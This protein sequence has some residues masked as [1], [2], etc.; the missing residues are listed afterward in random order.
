MSKPELGPQGSPRATQH[1]P[2]SVAD[3]AGHALLGVVLGTAVLVGCASTDSESHLT[4]PDSRPGATGPSVVVYRT[5]TCG[6]CK[7]YEDYL[8][9]HGYAIR[10]EVLDDLEPIRM[11]LD[12]PAAAASCH[13]VLI[14]GYAVEG[15][16]PV[17]AI[18]KMLDDRSSIDGISIPGMPSNAPGMGD[19]D[20]NPIEV[21]SFRD[22]SVEPFMTL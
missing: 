7:K 6:C 20:G 8:R 12:I 17:E 10:S 4:A 18:D 14:D 1:N 11:E 13:T 3:R 19:P 5:P 15:H 22:G 21:V 16:V 2:R 9:K